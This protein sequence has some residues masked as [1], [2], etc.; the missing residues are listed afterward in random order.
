[1][2]L[3]L[4]TRN[5]DKIREIKQALKGLPVA[6][7]TLPKSKSRLRETGKTLEENALQKARQVFRQTRLPSLAD[8]S[9]LEVD[10]LKGAPGVKSS[11]FAGKNAT[12][13]RNCV[14]L[15]ERMQSVPV[16]KRKAKFRCVL[17]LVLSPGEY[18]LAEGILSGRI[19]DKM[20]GKMG[21]GYDP[22][23]YLPAR[24]RTLAQLSLTEK[25][26]IS[27]RGRALAM[28]RPRLEKLARKL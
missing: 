27:H 5:R 6:V 24:K 1:M 21:F 20:Q 22:V 16:A 2:K 18:F 13:F 11:R 26:R 28:L 9:G 15:L 17:A 14:K 3:V 19:L 23:F 10:F 8:D 25:N 7:S 12:Y 4:A